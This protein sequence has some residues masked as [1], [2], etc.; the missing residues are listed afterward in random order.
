MVSLIGL[1]NDKAEGNTHSIKQQKIWESKKSQI[2]QLFSCILGA[3][4]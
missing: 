3:L 4:F 1:G 2:W